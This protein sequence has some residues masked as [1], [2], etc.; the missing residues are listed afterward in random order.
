MIDCL[1]DSKK[2][3]QKKGLQLDGFLAIVN[4]IAKNSGLELEELNVS[5]N[6]IKSKGVKQ[7]ASLL[8]E[9]KK[10]LKVID[11]SFTTNSAK[12]EVI[13]TIIS[14]LRKNL[15]SYINLTTLNFSGLKADSSSNV[16]LASYLS[17]PNN[18]QSFHF[19]NCNSPNIAVL[20]DGLLRGKNLKGPCLIQFHSLSPLNKLL[21][22]I[23]FSGYRNFKFEKIGY[24]PKQTKYKR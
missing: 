15:N 10:S 20:F 12:K 2:Q 6:K 7:L 14:G 4:A 8:L 9:S 1:I 21:K 3:K 13:G 22:F 23:F 11:V 19:S 16:Q 5:N 24:Q 17:L 18:I